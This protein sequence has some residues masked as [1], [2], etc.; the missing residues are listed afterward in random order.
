VL[1]LSGL[2][3]RGG[4]GNAVIDDTGS[5]LRVSK[6]DGVRDSVGLAGLSGGTFLSLANL[7]GDVDVVSIE[8]GLD[9]DFGG[10]GI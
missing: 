6:R 1:L 9:S 4:I 2:R 5:V 3:G 8:K 7:G 10:C